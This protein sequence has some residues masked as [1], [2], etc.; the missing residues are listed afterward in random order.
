M[1]KLLALLLALVM[2]MSLAACGGSGQKADSGSKEAAE[3]AEEAPAEEEAPEEEAPAEEAD[4]EEE[5]P[6][7]VA[8]G[9]GTDWAEY[10]K[11]KTMRMIVGYAAGGGSDVGARFLTQELEKELDCTIVV[12][13]I[14]GAGGWLAW[15][16]LLRCEPDG[17]TLALITDPTM[18]GGYLDPSNNRPYTI[19]DFTPVMNHVFDDGVIALNIDE[20]RFTTIEEL[21]EYAKEN[22]VTATTTGVGSNT[23]Q[24]ILRLNEELGTK[25]VPV[26]ASGAAEARTMIMGGSVDVLMVSLG[27]VTTYH[28]DGSLKVIAVTSPERSEYLPDVPTMVEAG[29]P[30][31]HVYSARGYVGPGGMDPEMTQFLADAMERAASTDQH[32][33]DMASM[34]LR[35]NIIKTDEYAEMLY[36]D[37]QWMK[38]NAALFGWE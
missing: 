30:L 34:N 21:I 28:N 32:K 36:N 2:L 18:F 15:E 24:L 14:E 16:E 1:K 12:E 20:T 35:L 22:E 7:E 4:T 38:D 23:H 27:E 33:A 19:H 3:T 11:G 9:E 17:L 6:A 26:H 37:E 5:A 29:L 10:F 13:N 25:F 8:E 31:I